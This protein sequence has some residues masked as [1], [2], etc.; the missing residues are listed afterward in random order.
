MHS[1]LPLE[2]KTI[3]VTGTQA[4]QTI[5]Q[6]VAQ[7][8][9]EVQAFPLIAVQACESEDDAKWLQQLPTYDWLIFTSQNAVTSFVEK[10]KRLSIHVTNRIAVV[11]VKTK[12][13]LER[14]GFVVDF[15]PTIYSADV[16]VK[17]FPQVA[18]DAHCLFLRGN[19]AK[20]T[21]RDALHC[22]EWT[23][24]ETVPTTAYVQAF[25]ESLLKAVEPI[26]V[27]ASPSAVRV[28]AENIVPTIGW[29]EVTVA[30]I[31][32][33][34]TA[35]LQEY[36]AHVAVQPQVYTMQAVIEQLIGGTIK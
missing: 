32:H 21:I 36:G 14:H 31:G 2:G 28:Y 15:M 20:S 16:F 18:G 11:G 30:S 23:V 33:I 25:K 8:G 12:Q 1:K 4:V 7:Y 9:G 6:L 24:Y 3:Y 13:E 17:E 22:E 10:T 26:V 5:A 29:H 19:L 27:F 35:V 34:T